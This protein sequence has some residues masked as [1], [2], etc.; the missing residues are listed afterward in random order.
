[1]KK[2]FKWLWKQL[3]EFWEFLRTQTFSALAFVFTWVLPII[4]LHSKIKLVETNIAVKITG[5]GLMVGL[6][7][8]LK[9]YGKFK[10]K[11]E[12][13]EPKTR[14][15]LA[16][17]F[18]LLTLQKIITFGLVA[19]VFYFSEVFFGKIVDWFMLAL[20]PIGIGFVF[21]LIHRAKMFKKR[22]A[23]AKAKI[24]KFKEQIKKELEEEN[25]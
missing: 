9:W 7:V 24:E 6:F 4:M 14:K 10:A 2:F 21:N 1:M 19:G 16:L 20:I 12:A 11:I 17:Q 22:K 13:I 25:E 23:E 3:T 15:K 5:A 8:A 18:A